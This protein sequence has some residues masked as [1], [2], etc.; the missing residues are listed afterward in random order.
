MRA[1]GSA[2]LAAV[3]IL[4]TVPSS[5]VIL[6]RVS[7]AQSLRDAV[8]FSQIRVPIEQATET[9]CVPHAAKA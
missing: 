7:S 1:V 2:M 9:T 8:K 4:A 5:L 3:V 6:P